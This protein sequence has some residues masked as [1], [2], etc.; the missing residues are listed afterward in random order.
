MFR[1][2][3]EARTANHNLQI[4]SVLSFVAGIVNVAGFLAV[5]QLTTN[6]TG[7]FAYF[8][9]EIFQFN[10]SKS[11]VYFVYIISFFLGAIATS[12]LIEAL[13]VRS[14]I[15]SYI[16]PVSIEILILFL[17]AVF[18]NLLIIENA[19]Y[20]VCSLLF[21]MGL[22]NALVTKISNA[23]VRTT[24][25][26]GLFT[27]LGIEIA[28][29]FCYKKPKNKII[30]FSS[31]KLKLTIIIFFFIGGILGGLFYQKI[32]LKV[33]FIAEFILTLGLL[34]NNLK[35]KFILLNR[36]FFLTSRK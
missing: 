16:F 10:F 32:K 14:K 13:H 5:Q 4:A 6:V 27:D 28:Q 20:I 8:V 21:A 1:Q 22:Q 31:I 23:T 19:N 24:H 34:F 30:L 35:L 18:A 2:Q 12:F 33:L 9:D 36:K 15:N 11:I 7:H 29:L 3:G 26:T 17:I 25:L